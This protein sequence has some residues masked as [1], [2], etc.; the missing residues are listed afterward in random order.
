MKKHTNL[1]NA[2][3]FLLL[4]AAFVFSNDIIAQPSSQDGNTSNDEKTSYKIVSSSNSWTY[5][6]Y[7]T[8]FA[9]ANQPVRYRFLED[10]VQLGDR[11]YLQLQLSISQSS[12]NWIDK[13]LFREENGVIYVVVNNEEQVSMNFNSVTGDELELYSPGSDGA[14]KFSVVSV[15]TVELM[16]GSHRKRLGLTCYGYDD[17][18]YYWVEGIGSLKNAMGIYH[19]AISVEDRP[20]L[21]FFRDGEMIY[22][23]DNF[24]SCGVTSVEDLQAA[25]ISI[26]PN[27]AIDHLHIQFE[28]PSSQPLHFRIIH[29]NGAVI[30]SFKHP[31]MQTDLQIPIHDLQA[32]IYHLSW[33]LDG[34]PFSYQFVVSK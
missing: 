20:M 4:L 13:G 16:D 32:G 6:S 31:G 22:F 2:L 25:G 34:R 33:D 11:W 5:W 17:W 27:P 7:G 3:T 1:K 28:N 9:P 21:C 15:D 18:I 14:G 24:E 30:N 10:S 8:W 19:C 26:Y 12:G 29:S 23:N